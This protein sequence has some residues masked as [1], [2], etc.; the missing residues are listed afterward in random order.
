LEDSALDKTVTIYNDGNAPL[1]IVSVVRGSGSA[2]F[3]YVGPLAPFTVG[4]G[5]SAVITVRFTPSSVGDLSATFTVTS[6]DPDTPGLSFAV[7][8]TGKSRGQPAWKVFLIGIL[9]IGGCFG[10]FL[11]YKRWRAKK[12]GVDILARA[13]GGEVGDAG[14]ALNLD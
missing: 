14:D 12:E 11:Y 9:I 2:D 7:S 10:G 4:S 1:V 5:G 8:G 3:T 6:N 13:G